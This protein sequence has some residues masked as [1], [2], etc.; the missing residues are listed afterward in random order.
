MLPITIFRVP[1]P[2]D[3][4][5]DQPTRFDMSR[6]HFGLCRNISLGDVVT[7]NEL[8]SCDCHYSWLQP[9]LPQFLR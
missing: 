9:W 3:A 5:A 1:S 7:C 4:F 6:S 8:L 2:R